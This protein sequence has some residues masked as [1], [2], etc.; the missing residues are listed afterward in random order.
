MDVGRAFPFLSLSS[1]I[2][3]AMSRFVLREAVPAHRW[4]GVGLIVLGVALVAG[5]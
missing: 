2:V 3:V 1:V 5:T 4:A